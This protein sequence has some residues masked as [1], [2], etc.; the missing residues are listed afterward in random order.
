M[1]V[2]IIMGSDKTRVSIGTGNSEFHPLYLSIGN[3]SNAVRRAHKNALVLIGFL[4]IPKG[5]S[6]STLGLCYIY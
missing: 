3:V 2:P 6:S 1:F 5:K 4:A